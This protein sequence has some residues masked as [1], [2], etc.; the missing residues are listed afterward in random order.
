MRIYFGDWYSAAPT[1]VVKS[2]FFV[3][4]KNFPIS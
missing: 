2:R 1:V 3:V 4:S